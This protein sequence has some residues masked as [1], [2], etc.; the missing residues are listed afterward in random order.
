LAA[1]L[2]GSFTPVPA[3]WGLLEGSAWRATVPLWG[4]GL[5]SLLVAP[6]VQLVVTLSIVTAMSR[7]LRNP[8]NPSLTKPLAYALLTVVDLFVASLLYSSWF[9]GFG[10]ERATAVFYVAHLATALLL[11]SLVT[12]SQDVLMTWIWRLRGR[13]GWARDGWLLDRSPNLLVLVTLATIGVLVYFVGFVAPVAATG[14]VP[15]GGGPPRGIA[16]PVITATVL[17]LS[18]GTLFQCISALVRRGATIA[19]FC[20][21]VML[22]VGPPL[23]ASLL[24]NAVSPERYAPLADTLMGLSPLAHFAAWIVSLEHVPMLRVD[25]LA[26][27]L[28]LMLACYT[29]LFVLSLAALSRWLGDRQAV[30]AGKLA[31]MKAGTTDD[32]RFVVES[33]P[34]DSPA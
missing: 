29:A 19:L 4:F 22:F 31:E 1:A 18:L 24:G 7:K 33:T 9:E 17:L 11:V 34:V 15:L 23:T 21:V 25:M 12:P 6:V 27:S 2:L 3:F 28:P 13:T 8:L 14:N 20:L 16:P 10:F 5:P 30:V 32:R 26:R